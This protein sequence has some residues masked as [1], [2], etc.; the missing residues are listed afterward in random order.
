MAAVQV[1]NAG[2]VPGYF[3]TLTIPSRKVAVFAHVGP[4]EG[5]SDT[6]AKIFQ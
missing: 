5:I 2:E 3:F 4:L 6:W 1:I